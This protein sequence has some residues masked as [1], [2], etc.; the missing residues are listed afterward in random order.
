MAHNYDIK[1]LINV[2]SAI[3]L[4]KN[5]VIYITG[6]LS[7]LGKFSGDKILESYYK[8]FRTVLGGTKGTIVFPTHSFSL[9]RTK[10]AFIPKKTISETGALT[11]F[12]RKKKGSVRQLHP[13]SSTTAIGKYAKYICGNNSSHVYGPDSPFDRLIK[14]NAKFVGFGLEPGITATQVHHAE[15]MMNVPYRYTKEFTHK[16]KINNG[17]IKKKFYLFVLYTNLIN[18]KR[19]RNKKFFKYF[20]KKN[21]ILLKKLGKSYI[22]SYSISE[23]Y[24]SNRECLKKDIYSWLKKE[25]KVKDKLWIK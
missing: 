18:L 23:F 1:D 14:L 21:K 13:Y 20:L 6:N 12:L 9:L 2:Y 5:D 17:Y 8:A 24:N 11:E 22:Y 25:P 15:F 16:I 10:K 7:S 4:K 19:D 3:N